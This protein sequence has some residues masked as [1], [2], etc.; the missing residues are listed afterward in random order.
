MQIYMY[1][2]SP[3]GSFLAKKKMEE[4]IFPGGVDML[5]E[6]CGGGEESIESYQKK[7]VVDLEV[8]KIFYSSMKG[9]G[10]LSQRLLR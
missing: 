9:N 5:V 3:A 10:S 4:E 8:Y 7:R 1:R 2:Y 6:T